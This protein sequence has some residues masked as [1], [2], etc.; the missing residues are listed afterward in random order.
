[1]KEATV[2]TYG[3]SISGLAD[4]VGAMRAVEK[5]GPAYEVELAREDGRLVEVTI[6]ASDEGGE[7][8]YEEL[9]EATRQVLD[10]ARFERKFPPELHTGPAQA[11][12]SAY[13]AGHGKLTD[14]YLAAL[15]VAYEEQAA[16]SRDPATRVAMALGQAPQT[17]KGH[18]VRARRDG[19]LTD[20]RSGQKGGQATDK[21]REVL[22]R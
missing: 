20:T 6:R 10:K 11:M 13:T 1:M 9:R 7:L 16:Q 14:E 17:V 22:G 21:A 3:L 4:M 19:F 8:G 5:L 18:L 15:S 2:L 12:I